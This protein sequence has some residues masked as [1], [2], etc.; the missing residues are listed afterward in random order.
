M[1]HLRCDFFSEV[2]GLSTSMTV[3]LPQETSSQIG[4]RGSVHATDHPT[5]YLLHG[6]SDDDTVWCR[7]TSIERYVAPLGLAVIMPQVHRSFYTDEVHGNRYWTFLSEELPAIVRR[8]FRLS[9]RRENTFVAGLSMGGYG[10]LKWALRQPGRFAAAASLSGAL[11]IAERQRAGGPPEDPDRLDRIF[12]DRPV[13]G[14]TDDLMWLLARADP[15]T[16]PAPRLYVCCG[17]EDPLY[18]ENLTFRDACRSKGV[19]LTVDFG[20]GEHEWGYWDTKI[21]DVLA[22]LPLPAQ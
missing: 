13:A 12:G 15:A 8:F 6:L 21:Q 9:D 5:L 22:W 11:D 1:A 4:L 14:T 2:L 18:A 16:T 7:R 17:T 20:P 19:P 10:A 3:I